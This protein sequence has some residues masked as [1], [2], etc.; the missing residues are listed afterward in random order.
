MKKILAILLTV[1]MVVCMIPGAAFAEEKPDLATDNV[2]IEDLLY[3]G[4]TQTA[5]V[6]IVDETNTDNYTIT[7][8][9]TEIKNVGT[10]TATVKITNDS[11]KYKK[12][13]Q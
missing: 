9:A 2:T 6:S 12:T 13:A 5:N 10:Y 8:S 7:Y 4:N 1:C 11:S 3:N